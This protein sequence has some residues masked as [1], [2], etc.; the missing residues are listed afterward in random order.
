MDSELLNQADKVK[1]C[2][3]KVREKWP[4]VALRGYI[5]EV[6]E[7]NTAEEL[8][9]KAV[10]G[11]STNK[12][13]IDTKADLKGV[14]I[15]T[16]KI[17]RPENFAFVADTSRRGNKMSLALNCSKHRFLVSPISTVYEISDR[18]ALLPEYLYLQFKRPEFDRY[19]RFN[20]WGS[21]RETFNWDDM[22]RV[23]I[24]LPPIEVQRAVVAL[25][26]CAEEARYIAN[27]SKRQ[28]VQICPAM[29]QRV[30]KKEIYGKP[31]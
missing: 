2:N 23:K 3:A 19:A 16:Y 11:I 25:Y 14:K 28:L 17:V 10:R 5:K 20:S 18:D 21:A 9:A 31:A 4:L 24:P 13:F 1:T 29:I 15:S 7:R 30:A 12:D 27:E 8:D 6:N 26:H 22:C